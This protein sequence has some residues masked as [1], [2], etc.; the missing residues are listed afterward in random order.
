M[1]SIAAY[2]TEDG[3]DPAEEDEELSKKLDCNSKTAKEN[4]ENVSKI[5]FL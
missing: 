5:Y 3:N 4:L 2:A 1:Y